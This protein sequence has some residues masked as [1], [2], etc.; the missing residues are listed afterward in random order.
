MTVFG[1]RKALLKLF[2]DLGYGKTRCYSLSKPSNWDILGDV[3]SLWAD[4]QTTKMK[5]EMERLN[6]KKREQNE[7]Y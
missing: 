5:L 4:Y 6:N 1:L 3:I 2:R 7:T